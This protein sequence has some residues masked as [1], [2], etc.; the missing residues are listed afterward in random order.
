MPILFYK[1]ERLV[2][3]LWYHACPDNMDK[4][5]ILSS[6]SPLWVYILNNFFHIWDPLLEINLKDISLIFK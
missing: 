5:A 3:N 1:T 4:N 6:P 2:H